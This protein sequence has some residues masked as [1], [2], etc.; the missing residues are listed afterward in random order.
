KIEEIGLKSDEHVAILLPKG[1]EQV[2][3]V[4]GS[5]YAGVSYLPLSIGYPQK[6][7]D[8]LLKEANVKVVLGSAET[9][10][11]FNSDVEYKIDIKEFVDI[12]RNIKKYDIKAKEESLAYTIFTSGSTGQSKGV[13]IS[14]KNIY[15]TVMDI[16]R[17]FK[18][19]NKDIIFN[20]SELN[21]DLSVYDIYGGLA[22]GATIII[23][24]EEKKLDPS[25]WL[26]LINKEGVSIWNSV[27]SFMQLFNNEVEQK[28]TT[29][30]SSLRLVL[31]SGD[32]IPLE[33]VRQI[34][35][36]SN[37]CEII[38]LGGATEASIWSI[39]YP[40][41]ELESDKKSIPYGYPLANQE[42]YIV[43]E[44]LNPKPAFVHGEICIKGVGIAQGYYKDKLKTEKQF[45]RDSKSGEVIYK[46]GDIGFFNSKGYIE[47]VGRMDDQVKIRGFRI[48]LGEIETQLSNIDEIKESVVLAKEDGNGNKALVAYV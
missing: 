5:G 28:N 8:Y 16:N 34:E 20:I 17:R 29:F 44:A 48:E 43:D 23:P 21:F 26:K 13:M 30:P 25:H 12:N 22:A 24:K 11:I 4:L 18:V 3:S 38:S 47:I 36:V 41:S 45:V 6:R 46:T 40:L 27:P 7:I 35:K 33:L 15:N 19:D 32:V 39:Y 10:E 9:F 31:M 37:G 1:W 42:I 14:H 2:V